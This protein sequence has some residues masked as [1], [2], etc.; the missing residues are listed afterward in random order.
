MSFFKNKF[1]TYDQ[2]QGKSFDELV[3]SLQKFSVGCEFGEL[4]A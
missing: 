4:V 1:V 2:V 3:T